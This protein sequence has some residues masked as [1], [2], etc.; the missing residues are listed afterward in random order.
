MKIW[1][2]DCGMEGQS[3]LKLLMNTDT[4]RTSRKQKFR[5]TEK[6]YGCGLFNPTKNTQPFNFNLVP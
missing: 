5:M 4:L 6:V 1:L 2:A 3:S